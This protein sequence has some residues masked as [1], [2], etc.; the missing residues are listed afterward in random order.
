VDAGRAAPIVEQAVLD[1]IRRALALGVP[2]KGSQI[3]ALIAGYEDLRCWVEERER[4]DPIDDG[5]QRA[6]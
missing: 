3:R 6:S 4:T 1:E 2:V 5:T